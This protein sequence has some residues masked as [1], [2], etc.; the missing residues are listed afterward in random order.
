MQSALISSIDHG[1]RRSASRT[2]PGVVFAAICGLA[3]V[4]A[5]MGAAAEA[6]DS[7]FDANP[8]AAVPVPR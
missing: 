5:L 3:L 8:T 1:P 2:R 7:M 6:A 4:S